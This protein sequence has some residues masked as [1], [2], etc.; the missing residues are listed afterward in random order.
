MTPVTT[1]GRAFSIIYALF[2]IPIA[3]L[4][5]KSIGEKLTETIPNVLTCVERRLLGREEAEHIQMK[6]TITVFVIMAFLLLTLGT[7]AH[8][9]EGWSYFEG[10]Y[11]AFVTLSTI[12]FGDFVPSH[13]ADP[14]K[15]NG[16]HTILF[17]ILTFIYITVGLAVVSS[18]LLSISRLFECKDHD[19]FMKVPCS[20]LDD[21]LILS[22]SEGKT[23]KTSESQ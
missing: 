18:A 10:I 23:G 19:E 16:L 22:E 1:W 5:L 17:T 13:P 11:F 3:G 8:A 21:S 2:G 12:G 6:S 20:E 9:Y 14:S 7:F 15:H 4:M